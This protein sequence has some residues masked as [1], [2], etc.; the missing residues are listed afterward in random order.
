MNLPFIL[1]V[2]LGLIFIYLILS[3]LASEIQ[4]LV[5][6]VFQWRAEHL[7]RSIEVL[8]SGD[9][10]NSE[11]ARII[12][13][14]N[15]IYANPLIKGINQEAKG[16]LAVLPRRF[17]WS[18]AS[19][20]RGFKKPQPGFQETVSVFGKENHSGPSYIPAETFATSLM[21]TLQ[22]P[23]LTQKL[24]E[25]RLESFK[26]QSLNEIQ[27]II[28]QLQDQ[29]IADDHFPQFL[30]TVYQG[31]AGVQADFEQVSWNF[32]QNEINLNDSMT[33]MA[34]SLDRY[35]NY[36][37]EEMP[38][39]ELSGKALRRLQFIRKDVF[40]DVEKS[41]SIGRLRPNIKEVVQLVN[42]GSN[43]YKEFTAAIQDQDSET[44]QNLHKVI[45]MLPDS[46][47]KKLDV[48]ADRAQTRVKNTGESIGTLRQEIETYFDRTMDRASGVYKR[49]AKGVALLIGFG[50]AVTANA[51]ALH[52]V[53]RLSK[54]S[55]LRD[56]ITNNAGEVLRQNPN[57]SLVNLENLKNQAEQ[58]LTDVSLP[59]GW[60]DVNLR[61]QIGWAPRQREIF[62]VFKFL[63][64]ILGWIIS[65]VAIAMGAPFWFDLLG[66][67]V[68]VRNTG[69]APASSSDNQVK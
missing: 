45:Q 48:L 22:I 17:T 38:K 20:Y 26:N 7:R 44:Y 14:A 30:S 67:V 37:Q 42:T 33:R 15:Q 12:Q 8:L 49:N 52:M 50:L 4:E 32:Q 19:F 55:A 28:F 5:A 64:M 63:S 9:A 16:F 51:D 31:F 25:S 40:N 11:E 65:G 41:I 13:L 68:N 54:D 34:E 23:T 58:V 3:L 47:A 1:D 56:T 2:S 35:I 66:K 57:S 10:E 43:V 62:P 46:V 18:I 53:E 36:F 27:D 39:D 59:I 69:K 61:Q 6:T 21:E 29:A 60:T 24:T